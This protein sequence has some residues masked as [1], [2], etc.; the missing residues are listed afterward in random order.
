MTT[1]CPCIYRY[2]F[3]HDSCHLPWGQ[4]SGTGLKTL[5]AFIAVE[6]SQT[7]KTE[8]GPSCV[9]KTL[10]SFIQLWH[11]KHV[12]GIPYNP[13]GQATVEYAHLSLKTQ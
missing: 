10:F 12:S 2:L 9:S 13:Q 6:V 7:I 3:S 4:K 8:Y 5:F 1:I 11:T